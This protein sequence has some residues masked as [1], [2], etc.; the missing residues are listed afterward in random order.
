MISQTFNRMNVG[1]VQHIELFTHEKS[2]TNR[3]YVYFSEIYKNDFA[4]NLVDV[5]K[6]DEQEKLFYAHNNEHV[7]WILLQ[8]RREYDGKGCK[9]EFKGVEFSHEELEF[10][11]SHN[12]D[13]SL[14]DAD[15][16]RSL[17]DTIYTLREDVKRL[18]AANS[19]LSS[20]HNSLLHA[21][22]KMQDIMDKWGHLARN[23]QVERLS[24]TIK[25][26]LGYNMME[27]DYSCGIKNTNAD[28]GRMTMDELNNHEV[29]AAEEGEVGF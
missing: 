26:D 24:K 6:N 14:V 18:Y 27:P 7:Y 12:P 23:N 16:A 4:K 8:C 11:N 3:A 13:F 29:V 17:E 5:L 22:N 28:K 25:K 10:M 19:C 21:C 1:K 2:N 15:Y 9:G 20:N